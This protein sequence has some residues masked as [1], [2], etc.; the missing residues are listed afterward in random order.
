MVGTHAARHAGLLGRQCGMTER[1]AATAAAR[2]T[3][4]R[5]RVDEMNPGGKKQQA[6][7][8]NVKSEG[9]LVYQVQRKKKKKTSYLFCN[10]TREPVKVCVL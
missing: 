4:R 5:S 9:R 1:P 6:V 10:M 2:G 8:E 3:R 7:L